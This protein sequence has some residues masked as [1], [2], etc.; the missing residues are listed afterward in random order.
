MLFTSWLPLAYVETV[1]PRGGL[2]FLHQSM[3]KTDI[4][5]HSPIVM[6][7]GKSALGLTSF[8]EALSSQ[9]TLGSVKQTMKNSPQQSPNIFN[10]RVFCSVVYFLDLLWDMSFSTNTPQ[11]LSTCVA[12]LHFRN[13]SRITFVW[14]VKGSS[15]TEDLQDCMGQ[16][17]PGVCSL[18]INPE[19]LTC[20]WK[21]NSEIPQPSFVSPSCHASRGCQLPTVLKSYKGS[22]LLWESKA[23]ANFYFCGM[24]VRLC[25][26]GWGEDICM[27][28]GVRAGGIYLNFLLSNRLEIG[29]S[30]L[31]ALKLSSDW[32]PFYRI[33]F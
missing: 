11:T 3:S 19:V 27:C 1:L 6:A 18:E 31:R 23:C 22:Q 25:G 14:C 5:R 9:V 13:A 16:E 33:E 30:L 20:L 7:T 4:L 15:S 32:N 28:P 17:A 8:F 2:G 12:P 26:L 29:L 10:C 21:G 24:R